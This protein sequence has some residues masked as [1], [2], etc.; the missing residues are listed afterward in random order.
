[1]VM[2]V[3]SW[4]QIKSECDGYRAGF[5][6]IFRKYETSPTDALDARGRAIKVSQASFAEH[7][8][9]DA[10]TFKR[11]V[12][13]VEKGAA[14]SGR[15]DS[16]DGGPSR[17]GQLGRQAAKS[18][19]VPIDAK[20]GMLDDLTSDREVMKQWQNKRAPVVSKSDAKAAKA[21]AAAVVQPLVEAATKLQVPMWLDQ[22]EAMTKGVTEGGLPVAT[23]D[24]IIKAGNE[25]VQ[26]AEVQKFG[27][28]IEV[29][30]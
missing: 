8:G 10:S 21:L 15:S 17:T 11:W 23:L 4:S 13:H 18:P 24:K 3:V 25:L 6:K 14:L 7:L 16:M 5:V 27:A 19:D 28:G 9:I 30:G 2:E 1:M 26:E 12:K 20:V 22:L 29:T